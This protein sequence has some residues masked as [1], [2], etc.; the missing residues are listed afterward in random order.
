MAN[1][2]DKLA[3]LNASKERV[4]SI[5]FGEPVTNV[6]AGEG[7]PHKHSYF[8]G[9]VVKSH[10]N[11]FGLTHSDHLA[12]CT[13]RKGKFWNTDIEVIYSGHLDSDK[14]TEL[15]EPIWEAQYGT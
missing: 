11:R 7:N 14:C 10:K 15:F 4:R 3:I 5:Q 13:D 6:C 1:I 2:T 9:Y 12:R 8:V